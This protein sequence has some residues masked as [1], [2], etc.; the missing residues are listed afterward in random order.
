MLQG[1]KFSAEI[2]RTLAPNFGSELWNGRYMFQ[3]F[4]ICYSFSLL[5]FCYNM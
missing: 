1:S 5:L 4:T 2:Q 3:Y